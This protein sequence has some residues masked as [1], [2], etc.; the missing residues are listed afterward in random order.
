MGGLLT[1]MRS[2]EGFQVRSFLPSGVIN[3][4]HVP[5]V[6]CHKYESAGLRYHKPEEVL[7]ILQM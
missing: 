4:H 5:H 7:C 2:P 1:D 3:R 6:P